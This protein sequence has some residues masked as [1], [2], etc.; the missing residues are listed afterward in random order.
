MELTMFST[1]K[2]AAYEMTSYE[3]FFSKL[4]KLLDPEDISPERCN[5]FE[6]I[7]LSDANIDISHLTFSHLMPI[8]AEQVRLT[9]SGLSLEE[10]AQLLKYFQAK[11]DKEYSVKMILPLGEEKTKN[12]LIKYH[13]PTKILVDTLLPIFERQLASLSESQK[14]P[15]RRQKKAACLSKQCISGHLSNLKKKLDIFPSLHY[16]CNYLF[17]RDISVKTSAVPTQED[18]A[19]PAPVNRL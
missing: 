6:D 7:I 8:D 18:Q 16:V 15:Y 9:I 12:S 11:A 3:L 10:T 1:S 19:N 4:E 14:D 5:I 2:R 13:I 17:F